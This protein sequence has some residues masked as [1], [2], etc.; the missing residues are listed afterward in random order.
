M[1]KQT[2][3]CTRAPTPPPPE[4]AGL[5]HM[6]RLVST[7]RSFSTLTIVVAGLMVVGAGAACDG[8]D[9]PLHG[10]GTGDGLPIGDL[11]KE[12]RVLTYVGEEPLEIF[13][14]QTAQLRFTR[15]NADGTPVEGDSITIEVHGSAVTAPGDA[16]TTDVGG[17]IEVPLAA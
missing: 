2:V 16:F 6:T 9:E 3:H 17:G 12:G 14:G 7:S 4:S 5:P 11:G 15:K 8:C 1:Y 13:L 10:P